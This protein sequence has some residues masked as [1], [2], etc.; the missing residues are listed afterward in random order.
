GAGTHD[1]IPQIASGRADI[2]A[3]DVAIL[4]ANITVILS[5]GSETTPYP[6]PEITPTI[7]PEITPEANNDL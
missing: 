4:P 1:V 6:S 3:Q 7:A 2:L 5:N